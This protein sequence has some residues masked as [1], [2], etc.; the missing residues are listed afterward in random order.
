[1]GG[2]RI[3][4]VAAV[5]V[6]ACAQGSAPN[7]PHSNTIGDGSD[8]GDDPCVPGQQ[9][10]CAC[11]DGGPG[12]QACEPD[13][14]GYGPCD[15]SRDSDDADASTS[16]AGDTSSGSTTTGGS[17]DATGIDPAVEDC[18]EDVTT[19]C[20]AC[21][22]ENCVAEHDACMANPDCVA[23]RACAFEAMCTGVDCLGPCGEV[24]EQHGGAGGEASQ[25]ALALS[26]CYQA[27]CEG[28]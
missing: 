16:T 14:S 20:E 28:C 21:E 24:I 6:C 4:G 11:P 2:G 18:L 1:M 5:L 13:G 25:L 3:V 9:I 27:A 17:T 10:E 22:C 15:C 8:D 19:T 12:A 23:I 26:N 7:E